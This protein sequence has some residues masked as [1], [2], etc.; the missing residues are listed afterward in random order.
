MRVE[1]QIILP[2]S[3]F[4]KLLVI[5]ERSLYLIPDNSSIVPQSHPNHSPIAPRLN[6]ASAYP[7]I[8][9]T[10]D[11]MEMQT[12]LPLSGVLKLYCKNPSF[13]QRLKT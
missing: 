11:W 3:Y 1:C 5:F 9:D 10:L 13:P 8:F 7:Q 2:T 6:P 4:S 12:G